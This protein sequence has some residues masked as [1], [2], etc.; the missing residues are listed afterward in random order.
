MSGAGHNSDAR[1]IAGHALVRSTF[2]QEMDALDS[3][4]PACRVAIYDARVRWSAIAVRQRFK[5]LG[6]D[7]A[8]SAHDKA[9]AEEL[10]TI[11]A[12]TVAQHNEESGKPVLRDK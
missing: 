12:R 7:P 1:P 8:N 2:Q 5:Q 6:L 11:D 3:L 9:L 10:R 4:G